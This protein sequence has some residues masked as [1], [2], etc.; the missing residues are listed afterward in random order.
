MSKEAAIKVLAEGPTFKKSEGTGIQLSLITVAGDPCFSVRQVY[1][2]RGSDEWMPTSKG[3]TLPPDKTVK[4]LKKFAKAA[5][6][7][8]ADIEA[9]DSKAS[10]PSKK[11]KKKRKN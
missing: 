6:Q 1:R 3:F 4:V 5:E 9:E 11:L 2:P 7:I 8:L 10:K